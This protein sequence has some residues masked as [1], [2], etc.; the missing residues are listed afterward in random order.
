MNTVGKI[1]VI[2]N[3]LF[4]VIVGALVVAYVATSNQW[5]EKFTELLE[6]TNMS[7]KS[8]D[9]TQAVTG[10]VI[11][12][13][14]DL[15]LVLEQN[16]QKLKDQ[17]M[18]ANALKASLE[19]EIAELKN[20]LLDKDVTVRQAK[21]LSQRQAFENAE[22]N[23]Y[24]KDRESTIVQ[25]QAKVKEFRQQAQ[26]FES[27]AR[28]RQIQNE[29]L[30]VQIGDL[31]RALALKDSGAS[32]DRMIIRNPND[33]NPPVF[34]IDGKIEKVEGNLVQ[35][36]LGTDHGL[37]ENN[38]LDVYRLQPN[39]QYL[40]MIR[41]VDARHHSSVG[42]LIPSGSGASKLQPREGDLVTSKFK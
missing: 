2:L 24:I 4:A 20:K 13:N 3:F 41:I 10:N 29:G 8:R 36:T 37:Q 12:D 40:G 35:L 32:P 7:T 6:E 42:R 15:R 14:K 5:K 1:L 17:E 34:K 31:T 28:T 30:L 22:L 11:N 38:T 9:V 25:L 27:I 18:A 23:K 26:N 33:P 39:P 21:E 16:N 19:V